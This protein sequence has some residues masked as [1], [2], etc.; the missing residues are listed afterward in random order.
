MSADLVLIARRFAT[1]SPHQPIESFEV[2]ARTAFGE[3]L[4]RGLIVGH[5]KRILAANGLNDT[6][7]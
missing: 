3:K 2:G 5:L 4:R 1:L 7:S 6:Q